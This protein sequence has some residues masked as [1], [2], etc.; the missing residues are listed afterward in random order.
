MT[1]NQIT[2]MQKIKGRKA[3]RAY[4]ARVDWTVNPKTGCTNSSPAFEAL[5]QDVE[6]MIRGAAH[7]L[8]AGRADGVA[9]GIVARLAHVY[10]CKPS[11]S[12]KSE[13]RS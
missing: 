6:S 8:I 12:I 11:N 5:C 7:S 9:R 1:P 2:R 13:D 4:C 10:G 3:R